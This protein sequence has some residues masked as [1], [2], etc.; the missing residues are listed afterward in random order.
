[1]ESTPTKS[2]RIHVKM[3]KK[4]VKKM[5]AGWTGTSVAIE[6]GRVSY[7]YS[8]IPKQRTWLRRRVSSYRAGL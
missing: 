7:W 1:M 4:G 6:S 8:T 3:R 2:S 5:A